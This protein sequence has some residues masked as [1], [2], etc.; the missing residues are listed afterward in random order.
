MKSKRGNLVALHHKISSYSVLCFS[1]QNINK[2]GSEN[3]LGVCVCL[4]ISK[5]EGLHGPPGRTRTQCRL[6]FMREQDYLSG[7]IHQR[8]SVM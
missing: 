8:Q 2:K 6:A 3:L 7:T 5:I 4:D 1:Q